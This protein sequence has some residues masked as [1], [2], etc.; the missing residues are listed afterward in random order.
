MISSSIKRFYS[1]KEF[2]TENNISQNY[3]IF[4]SF[5]P[6]SLVSH[7]TDLKVSPVN[8]L[9]VSQTD[10]IIYLNVEIMFYLKINQFF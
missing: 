5:Q 7:T 8:G 10:V 6:F 9:E 2:D 3:I 1:N 4:L